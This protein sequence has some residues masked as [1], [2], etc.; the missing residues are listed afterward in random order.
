MTATDWV[1]VLGAFTTL[2]TTIGVVVVRVLREL[3]STQRS[4]EDVAR[5][6][7]KGPHAVAQLVDDNER[8]GRFVRPTF[9]EENSD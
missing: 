8:S 1:T 7:A 4:L 2:V 5:A 6:A 3:K 9:P